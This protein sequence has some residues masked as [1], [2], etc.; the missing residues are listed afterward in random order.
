MHMNYINNQTSLK[1]ELDWVPKNEHIVWAIDSIVE[2]ILTADL[3][4]ES[5]WTG[6]PEYPAKMLLKMLL[7]AYS[8]KTF[9][10]RHIAEMA[11]ENLPMRWLMGNILTTPSHRTINRFRVN[12][13]SKELIKKLF[14]TFRDRLN[15][16]GLIDD[17]A[18]FIDGTKL[19][20]NAN[21]YTFVWRKSVEKFEPKLDAK[22]DKLYQITST[23]L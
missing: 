8:R 1:L 12:D 19:L 16:L 14:I 15:Q 21:K 10:G 3:E 2:S 13:K 7:F 5:S 23:F 22:A 17:S 9:S 18:L 4:S 11:E 20:A 6:R